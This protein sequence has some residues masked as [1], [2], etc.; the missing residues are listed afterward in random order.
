MAHVPGT[1]QQ[2]DEILYDEIAKRR[3]NLAGR[4]DVLSRLLAAG[5][6]TDE[7]LRDQLVTLLLAGH[8]T[9]ATAL[10]WTFHELARSPE[11]LAFGQRASDAGADDELEAIVKEACDCTRSCTRSAGESPRPRTSP[12][13][14]CHGYDD[15]GRDRTGP[16]GRRALPAAEGVPPAALPLGRSA[17][18]RHVDAVR[19]RGAAVHRGRLLTDGRHGD[20]PCRARRLQLHRPEPQARTGPGQERHPGPPPRLRSGR[21]PP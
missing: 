12:A 21:H 20:P 8:E 17:C 9:T 10:A 7:E 5:N 4:T 2:V 14:G 11:D 18:P 1:Q 16:P 19:R 6:W 13:T 15:H 3:G